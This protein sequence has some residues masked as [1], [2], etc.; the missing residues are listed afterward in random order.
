MIRQLNGLA[1]DRWPLLL[2]KYLN[3]NY[4]PNLDM[5]Y[6]NQVIYA[7]S[8]DR[9]SMKKGNSQGASANETRGRPRGISINKVK[10]DSFVVHSRSYSNPE[11]EIDNLNDSIRNLLYP[12]TIVKEQLFPASYS[13]SME[14]KFTEKENYSSILSETAKS[15][16][17]PQERIGS[18]SIITNKR[19]ATYANNTVLNQLNQNARLD[20]QNT[21]NQQELQDAIEYYKQIITIIEKHLKEE[22]N[23]FCQL[24]KLFRT[25]F[26]N[27]YK[28]KIQEIKMNRSA[29]S[30]ANSK[31]IERATLDLQHFIRILCHSINIFY[32]LQDLKRGKLST[33]DYTVFN[34]DNISNF[35]TTT[36][37]DEEIYNTIYELYK[38]ENNNL[39]KLYR[40]QL[41]AS[42]KCTPQDFGV[43]NFCCLN[44][45]T[46][47][48]LEKKVV[49]ALAP[50]NLNTRDT[51]TNLTDQKDDSQ[52]DLE[53]AQKDGFGLSLSN[54]SNR[55]SEGSQGGKH[56][57]YEKS[58]SLLR[59]LRSQKSPIHKLKI[60]MKVVDSITN[61]IETFYREMNQRVPQ[62]LTGEQNFAIFCYILI[63]SGLKNVLAH[64][65]MIQNF[66]TC[67]D[68]SSIS[69]YYTTTLEICYRHIANMPL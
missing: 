62:N 52:S 39:E 57:P 20:L 66:S 54:F 37:F 4:N 49:S 45:L 56:F 59:Q 64:C 9:L 60:I 8:D 47:N 69:G 18:S 13:D 3:S 51:L 24:I 41:K 63:K 61:S 12:S 6:Q 2:S 44:E 19:L 21:R 10:G 14:F 25:Y 22:K 1:F 48:H 7:V 50:R 42:K 28:N 46:L 33:T 32:N 38:L 65:R 36:I 11:I 67:N 27:T 5:L 43:P 16:D 34:Y 17:S 55:I 30:G 53:D 58:I 40:K 68:M 23:I 26:L 35:I 15:L 31:T 29:A